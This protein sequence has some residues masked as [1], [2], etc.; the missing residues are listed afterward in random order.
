[1]LGAMPMP[2]SKTWIMQ[3]VAARSAAEQD[4]AA[5]GVFDGVA[6]DVVQNTRQ[7]YRVGD[8]V[9]AAV[10]D[11]ESEPLPSRVGLVLVAQLGEYRRDGEGTRLRLDAAEFQ[12]RGFQNTVERLTKASWSRPSLG[13]S[14]AARA[15]RAGRRGAPR[16]PG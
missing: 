3:L 11:L 16:R 14:S 8:N 5:G 13:R 9:R 15:R 2:V 6:D 10:D 12:T 4:G 7:H 1:M